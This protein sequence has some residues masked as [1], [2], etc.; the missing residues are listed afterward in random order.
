MITKFKGNIQVTEHMYELLNVI[1][2]K[3]K[4]EKEGKTPSGHLV[5]FSRIIDPI[6]LAAFYGLYKSRTL[7]PTEVDEYPLEKSYE[8]G[9]IDISDFADKINHFLFCLW[10][11][12]NGLPNQKMNVMDY[13]EKLYNF[14]SKIISDRYFVNVIIPFYV[15]KA[16]EAEGERSSFVHRLWS[17]DTIP[18]INEIYSPEYLAAEFDREQTDFI[19]E[20]IIPAAN[21]EI[22]KTRIETLLS[23][24][25]N[26]TLEFK[27]TFLYDL[28]AGEK[29]INKANPDLERALLKEICAFMNSEGGTI[30]I[31]ISDD[32]PRKIIGLANDYLVLPTRKKDRD[33]FEV[34]LRNVIKAFIVPEVPGSVKINFETQGGLEVCLIEVEKS[35]KQIFLKRSLEGKEIGEFWIREGNTTSQLIGPAMV[36]YIKKH[37]H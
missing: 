16:D 19:N 14:I 8:F 10:V 32:K 11:K 28:R 7:P 13:R 15:Q 29:G 3:K 20:V 6:I 27:S 17:S 5:K 21:L 30:V 37:W 2:A 22:P 26:Q 18:I 24:D 12:E 23:I 9:N 31:G 25:E 33:G 1:S 36:E 4:E 35:D 34:H